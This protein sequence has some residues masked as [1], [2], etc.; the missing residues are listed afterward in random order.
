MKIVDKKI[1]PFLEKVRFS[2]SQNFTYPICTISLISFIPTLSSSS[3]EKR[4]KD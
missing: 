3:I 4:R 2:I 1:V